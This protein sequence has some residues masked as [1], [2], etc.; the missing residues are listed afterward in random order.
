MS[1]NDKPVLSLKHWKALSLSIKKQ[2]FNWS[3]WP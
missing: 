1:E 3:S 2:N